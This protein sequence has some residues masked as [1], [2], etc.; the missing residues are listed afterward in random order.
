[1]V[2]WRC[3]VLLV[4]HHWLVHVPS[5]LASPQETQVR[6][7]DWG[8]PS[9]PCSYLKSYL[10]SPHLIRGMFCSSVGFPTGYT[11][12]GDLA[13][14]RGQLGWVLLATPQISEEI[15][16]SRWLEA[17][18]TGWVR[19][20][21]DPERLR[22]DAAAQ[23]ASSLVK[24]LWSTEDNLLWAARTPRLPTLRESPKWLSLSL[25]LI[26]CRSHGEEVST[27][28]AFLLFLPHF[29]TPWLR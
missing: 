2:P 23:L 12:L 8:S 29:L 27:F 19:E 7:A 10:E 1:M 15:L 22:S 24:F 25:S 17:W 14:I 3:W 16:L 13:S 4:C 5:G 6:Q 21:L 18:R 11:M 26:K 28:V 20:V 9:A